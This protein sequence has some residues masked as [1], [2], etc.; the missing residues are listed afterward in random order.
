[1]SRQAGVLLVTW[2]GA[3]NLPPERSLVR[4]LVARGHTVRALAR[5]S[6]R[7]PLERDGAGWAADGTSRR[8]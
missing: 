6:V 5:E 3:G 4:S 1:M 2:D 8:S 7:E